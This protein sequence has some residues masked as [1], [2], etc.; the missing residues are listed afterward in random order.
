MKLLV[1][2]LDAGQRLPIHA[3]LHRDWAR[4][5]VGAAHGKA[6]AWYLLTPGYVYLGL[7]EDVSLEGLLDLVVRQD[8]DAMLGKMMR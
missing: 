2:L 5:H 3:H 4:E 7:K 8:I 1:K 6:E